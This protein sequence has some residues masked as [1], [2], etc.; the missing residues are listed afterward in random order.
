MNTD[1]AFLLVLGLGAVCAVAV[2]V[3]A[4]FDLAMTAY[5]SRHLH[6]DAGF[7][8][9]RRWLRV[10]FRLSNPAYFGIYGSIAIAYIAFDEEMETLFSG[11]ALALVLIAVAL[12][13]LG[14][15]QVALGAWINHKLGGRGAGGRG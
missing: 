4:V 14:L 13:I 11:Q 6:D 9:A 5:A 12:L 7:Q 1:P 3:S 10:S 8:R 2:A 15:G